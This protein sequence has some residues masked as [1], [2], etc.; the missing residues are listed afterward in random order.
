M[1]VKI[2]CI[3]RDIMWSF[4]MACGLVLLFYFFSETPFYQE[5]C[6][7]CVLLMALLLFVVTTAYTFFCE[8]GRWFYEEIHKVSGIPQA[9]LVKKDTDAYRHIKRNREIYATH[10]AGHV[11][12]G[13]IKGEV[14]SVHILPS[15]VRTETYVE[16]MSVDSLKKKILID[17]AGAAAEELL[18]GEISCGSML[19]RTADFNIA[20]E[21]I[22]AYLVMKDDSLSKSLLDVELSEKVIECSREFY[23]EA[24]DILSENKAKVKIVAS[25]LRNTDE[26]YRGEIE[27]LL[28]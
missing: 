7:S 22:K 23:K 28:G 17:Y 2:R 11:V 21:H 27:S 8:P 10:E 14:C 25:V 6:K 24:F 16:G 19:E 9:K 5:E 13:Y 12:M 26:L 15:S 18:L 3:F 4:F 1:K 20:V